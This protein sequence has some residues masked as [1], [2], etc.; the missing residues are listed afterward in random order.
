MVVLGLLVTTVYL[1]I[2]ITVSP[3]TRLHLTPPLEMREAAK[4]GRVKSM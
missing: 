4:E 1:P 2:R 3:L